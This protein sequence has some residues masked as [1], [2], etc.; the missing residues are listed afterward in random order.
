MEINEKIKALREDYD[1]TQSDIAKYLEQAT[2]IIR[3]TKRE[4]I[5]YQ[6]NI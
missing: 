4:N 2:N 6:Y 1:L 3:N 5:Q